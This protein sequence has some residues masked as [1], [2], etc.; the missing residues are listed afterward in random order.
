MSYIST[1][2]VM[3]HFGEG[4]HSW[5]VTKEA[6]REI[7]RVRRSRNLPRRNLVLTFYQWLYIGSV[8]YCPTAYFTKVTLLLL[9]V[10]VFSAFKQVAKA[11]RVFIIVTLLLYTPIMFVKAFICTPIAAAWD[12]DVKQSNC[13]NQRKVFLS[14]M[15]LGV[16][17][18]IIILILPLPLTYSLQMPLRTKIKVVALLSAGGVA[19][20]VSIFRLYE[21]VLFLDPTDPTEGFVL[22]DITT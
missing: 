20:G 21:A 2:L 14:D 11:I 22:L 12:L 8:I 4:Y 3:A 17:T 15:C 5:E 16:L 10:R 7:M 6:Y 18:D 9:E 19:T 13:L 1:V